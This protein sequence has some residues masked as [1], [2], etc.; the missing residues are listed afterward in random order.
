MNGKK[1]T[2]SCERVLFIIM[3]SFA[4]FFFWFQPLVFSF[5]LVMPN[6]LQVVAVKKY[7]MYMDGMT[8]LKNRFTFVQ[9]T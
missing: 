2:K 5:L 4:F 6:H 1:R 9:I 3:N 7:Q 8:S